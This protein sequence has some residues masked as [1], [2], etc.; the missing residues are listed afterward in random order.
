MGEEASFRVAE[1]YMGVEKIELE[2]KRNKWRKPNLKMKGRKYR[3]LH[4]MASD[5]TTV[6]VIILESFQKKYQEALETMDIW[7]TKK[8]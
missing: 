3:R 4:L 8:K 1:K 6:I 5:I 2:R 7:N